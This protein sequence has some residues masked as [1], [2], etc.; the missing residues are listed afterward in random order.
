[1]IAKLIRGSF[2]LDG[3]I[4]SVLLLRMQYHDFFT[5]QSLAE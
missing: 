4:R 5:D 1:M 3:I 2:A